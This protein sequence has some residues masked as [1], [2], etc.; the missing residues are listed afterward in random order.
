MNNKILIPKI[1]YQ[2]INISMGSL[3]ARLAAKPLAGRQE[4]QDTRLSGFFFLIS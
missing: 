4:Y 2:D 1:V 3:P